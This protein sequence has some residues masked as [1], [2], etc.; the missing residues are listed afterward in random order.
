M[1]TTAKGQ[2]S[3]EARV[4]FTSK[5]VSVLSGI[6]RPTL[7][8]WVEKDVLVPQVRGGVGRKHSHQF[9][10]RQLLGL[11]FVAHQMRETSL[12]GRRV[13]LYAASMMIKHMNDIS[14]DDMRKILR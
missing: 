7:N 3:I 2:S 6:G 11:T 1:R 14:D 12:L 13:G 4:L 8:R 9:T 10:A 5:E